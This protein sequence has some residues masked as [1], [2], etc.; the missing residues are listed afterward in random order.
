MRM[1]FFFYMMDLH[2]LSF[3]HMQKVKEICIV[4]DVLVGYHI[5]N[6][7]HINFYMNYHTSNESYFYESHMNTNYHIDDEI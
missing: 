1:D 2:K 4:I 3:C 6:E 5:F 7:S